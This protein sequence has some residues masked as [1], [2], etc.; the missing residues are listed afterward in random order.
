MKN[1]T[2]QIILLTVFLLY[3]CAPQTPPTSLHAIP[4][5]PSQTST[6]IP[7]DQVVPTIPAATA[8]EVLQMTQA[9]FANV[10]S[11]RVTGNPSAYQFAVEISS[12]DTGCE[13]YADWWEIFT[14]EGELLYRRILLHSHVTEQPF[15]R[16]GGPV[17][18]DANT[19]V[20]VRAHMN[21]LGYGGTLMKG[22]VQGRFEP[23][24]AEA[25]L[26]SGLEAVPPLPE[27]CAF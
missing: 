3:A 1:R 22:S 18:I 8:T 10:L 11:V 24:E 13:Q 2:Y 23:A 25:S 17:E 26:G 15:T 12:P 6:P 4:T 5:E 9:Q 16:S 21:N 27:D 7:T 14:E 19:V 20:Y